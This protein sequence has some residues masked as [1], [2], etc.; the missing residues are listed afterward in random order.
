MSQPENTRKPKKEMKED[1]K[2][3]KNEKSLAKA[4]IR[5]ERAAMAKAKR[6]RSGSQTGLLRQLI[7]MST[8]SDRSKKVHEEKLKRQKR[9]RASASDITSYIG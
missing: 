9:T 2:R 8:K 6:E 4:R 5:T 7:G 1:K 3:L